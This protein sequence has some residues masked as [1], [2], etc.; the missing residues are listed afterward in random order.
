MSKN[1]LSSVPFRWAEQQ[2]RSVFCF[3]QVQKRI[4]MAWNLCNF[5]AP[6]L[7]TLDLASVSLEMLIVSPII[8]S[9]YLFSNFQAP[10]LNCICYLRFIS[11]LLSASIC[12]SW[13]PC[14]ILILLESFPVSFLFS[15]SLLFLCLQFHPLLS[16]PL[17]FCAIPKLQRLNFKDNGGNQI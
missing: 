11:P 10:S 16:L 4:S 14:F 8:L 3:F 1:F 13:A 2:I 12:Y 9:S 15:H 17:R 7:Q 6:A 5:A